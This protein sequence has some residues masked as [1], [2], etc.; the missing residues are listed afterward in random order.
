VIA[1]HEA[2]LM[3]TVTGFIGDRYVDVHWLGPN[4]LDGDLTAIDRAKV[5]VMLKVRVNEV[6]DGAWGPGTADLTDPWWAMRTLE[7]C[8]FDYVI[9]VDGDYPEAPQGKTAR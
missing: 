2:I 3:F 6:L 4:Q 1:A 7:E 8:S 9:S 5:A